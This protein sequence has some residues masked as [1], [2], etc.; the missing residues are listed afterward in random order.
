M[1]GKRPASIHI[2]AHFPLVLF[3]PGTL[4][5][6]KLS[7]LPILLL[8]HCLNAC[9]LSNLIFC[10]LLFVCLFVLYFCFFS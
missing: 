8:N 6:L 2:I 10:F 9:H 3:I 5:P 7:V 4:Y 1:V